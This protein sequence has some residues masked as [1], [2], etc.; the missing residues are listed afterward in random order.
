MCS[1]KVSTEDLPTHANARE[2]MLRSQGVAVRRVRSERIGIG[3]RYAV[4]AALFRRKARKKRR[5]E[6]VSAAHEAAK[7]YWRGTF[8]QLG[9]V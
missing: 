8:H 4:R 1:V 7:A 6:V 9:N 5:R 2:C 3:E